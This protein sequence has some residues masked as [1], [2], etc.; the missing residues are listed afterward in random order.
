[1]KS[2]FSK[3]KFDN[4]ISEIGE[5]ESVAE[6]PYH[7][8]ELLAICKEVKNQYIDGRKFQTIINLI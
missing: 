4:H 8:E 5:P 1:M 7:H 6:S 2:K 3:I